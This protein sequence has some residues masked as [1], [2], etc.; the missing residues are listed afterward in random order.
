MGHSLNKRLPAIPAQ[1]LEDNFKLALEKRVMNV[2]NWNSSESCSVVD[3]LVSEELN[4]MTF[5]EVHTLS[6]RSVYPTY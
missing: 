4:I 3:I 6:L 2:L 1:I 5:L